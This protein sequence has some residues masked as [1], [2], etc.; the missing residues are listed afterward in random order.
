M[1]EL[2]RKY[3]LYESHSNI[4]PFIMF[5]TWVFYISLYYFLSMLQL[6]QFPTLQLTLVADFECIQLSLTFNDGYSTTICSMLNCCLIQSILHWMVFI[7]LLWLLCSSTVPNI[8]NA[9]FILVAIAIWNECAPKIWSKSRYCR[10][11]I[12][13]LSRNVWWLRNEHDHK[14]VECARLSTV[15]SL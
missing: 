13:K 4:F 12:E 5:H 3:F 6:L 1:K 11:P 8:T 7:H 14:H 9:P 10:R 2:W 15:N